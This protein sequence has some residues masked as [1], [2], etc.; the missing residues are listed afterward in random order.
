MCE[1]IAISPLR[2]CQDSAFDDSHAV[3]IR[4]WGQPLPAHL[5]ETARINPRLLHIDD[6]YDE[7]LWD[8]RADD[9]DGAAHWSG[10]KHTL[11]LDKAFNNFQVLWHAEPH[12]PRAPRRRAGDPHAVRGPARLR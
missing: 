6:D 9:H 12:A 2:R 10:K 11:D 5:V 3:G 4:Y 1:Y 7:H 8:L